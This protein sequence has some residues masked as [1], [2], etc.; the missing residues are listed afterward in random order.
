MYEESRDVLYKAG[1]WALNDHKSANLNMDPDR[2]GTSWT[3]PRPA[4]E[5]ALAGHDRLVQA[6]VSRVLRE[7]EN[8]CRGELI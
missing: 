6:G 4:S 2:S 1:S 7:R 3:R 5:E 8:V